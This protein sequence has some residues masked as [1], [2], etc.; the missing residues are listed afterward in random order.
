MVGTMQTGAEGRAAFYP[1]WAGLAAGAD[2]TLAVDSGQAQASATA[3]AG[4]AM[5]TVPVAGGGPA[6]TGLDLA[7]VIDTTGSMGDE[8]RY[9]EGELL[10]IS[11]SI[12]ELYPGIS[13]RWA[14][15]AYRDYIDDYVTL[16]RDFSPDVAAFQTSFASLNASGGGDYPEAPEQGLAAMNRLSWRDGAVARVA[17]WIADAPH[18]AEHVQELE[19]AIAGARSHGIHLYPVAA[20]G[21]DDLLE[22]SMRY[23]ALVTGGR[24]LFLTNDSGIGDSHMEPTVP[25]Y[26][27][28]SLQ[29]AMLRMVQIELSGTHVDPSPADVIRTG[30][31]PQN[32]RCQLAS[33]EVVDLL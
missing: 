14:Y 13:Q 29:K 21:S 24:Y 19:A 32:G 4:D 18:H 1:S 12:N 28:T 17:F 23:A 25:C 33:G 22:F 20:S 3:H 5:I 9:L 10:T 2:I 7:I 15:V 11:T 6:V 30:G 8:I 16:P 26:F 31:D 27:V